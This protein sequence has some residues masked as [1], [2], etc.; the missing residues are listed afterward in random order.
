MVRPN[1][2]V[3]ALLHEY[4][5]LIAITGGEAFKAR[6]YEK[7]ARA[8][9]GYPADVSH[10][11][12]AGLKEIP[13]VGKSIAEK[14]VEYFRTGHVT[15]VEERRAEIP[16]GVRQL[17]T[18]PTLGPRK[19]MA[20]YE[21]LHISSVG[22]LADAIKA[23]KLRDLKGFGEKTE[24]NILHG[25]ALMQQAGGRILLS[26]AM[27]AAEDIVAELSR[28]TGCEH[29][30]YAGSLRRM[31]ETIGDID[32][33]VAA[34]RA[35][36][37]MDALTDLPST[38]EV[39]AHGEKKTSIRTV[40]GV[41]VDLRVV[42]PDA[43]GAGMQYFTGS[44]AHNIRTRTIAV[45]LGLKLSEYGL[46]ETEGGK[47]VAS[48][49][50]DE[51]YARLGLPWIPP[52]LREDRG[53]IEAGL[54]GE[55]PEVVTERD[56]RGDLHTHTDLTDGLTPLED[57][58]AAAAQRGYA[59][60][61]VTDHAPNLYMQRM[62]DEKILAQREQVRSLDGEHHG[63][64]LLHGTELNI[65]PE[66]EVDWPD[67]FLQGFDLC[68]AAVHSHFNLGRKA[69]TRRFVRA[70][71][72]PH[73]NIIGH[74]TTRLLGKRPGIDADLDEVFAAC[75]RTGTA[76]EVDAQPDRL[77]LGDEDIL[78]ARSHGAKFAIDTDAHSIPQLACLRYGIGTA[79]RGWLTPDD[80]IN[81]WP[82]RRLRRFLRKDRAG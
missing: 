8:I 33:L 46:F 39:I 81:T 29:C 64:R 49:S 61:A 7:A 15:V 63:M 28:I 60:Y 30:A 79:Q 65:G 2:E 36:P 9:G 18:I 68:V 59:Y 50:E 3:E 43:W 24:E 1:E 38:A 82:L 27:E 17:I 21:D 40:K 5:D 80:V 53:E 6:A 12:V 13:G 19:A 73:V 54:R 74:P 25:I 37:F 4:A 14:V 11:D 23:E 62:T 55:L 31:K 47:R 75:A 44:K 58:V 20:L 42:R 26:T 41:Q 78:R 72:N 35:A 10:L 69:M 32:I 22:E 45:H 34:R 67:E 77:D 71:E 52:A 16:A 57:M 70:C 76:L 48:R 51:V 66:G 56:I